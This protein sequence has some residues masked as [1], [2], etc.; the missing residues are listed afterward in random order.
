MTNKNNNTPAFFNGRY[1]TIDQ[2]AIS[3]FDRGFLLGDSLY[4]VVPVYDGSMLGGREHFRRLMDGLESI[5]IES[6]YT[7]AD[8]PGVASPVL[9]Q[10]EAAQLLYIQVT[11][12]DEQTRKH[13]FPID[14][15]PT[16]LIFSIPFTPPIDENYQGCAGHL[17][18]DL[19]WQRCN[20]KSTSLMGNV[21][22]YQQLYA[23]GFANDEALL[24]RDGLVVEAPSSNLFMAKDG[25]I[26]TPPVDNILPGITRTLVI[27]IARQWGLEVREQAPDIA[28]F[29]KADEVWVTNSMEELKPVVSIDGKAVG[30][31]LP[32]DIWRLLFKGFQ[33]LKTKAPIPCSVAQDFNPRAAEDFSQRAAD[34][35]SL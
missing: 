6:P 17:Q 23:D 12:G 15:S 16:V 14:V 24:V 32:G 22:A 29:L 20:I 2:V 28:T 11:R 25:V 19:R 4:E 35:S 8:W 30:Q 13:R 27:D 3:P 9:Q 5:G 18:D 21:L 34:G 1:T 7:L 10:D 33:A 26:F 31:G